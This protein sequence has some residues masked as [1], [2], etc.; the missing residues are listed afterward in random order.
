MAS[1]NKDFPNTDVWN[2]CFCNGLFVLE[3]ANLQAIKTTGN[4]AK[5]RMEVSRRRVNMEL[6]ELVPERATQGISRESH[7]QAI[8]K[9]T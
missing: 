6:R 1:D 5:G 9:N 7:L 2:D 8:C 3:C 4:H